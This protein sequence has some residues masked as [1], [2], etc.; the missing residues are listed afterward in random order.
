MTNYPFSI[1][2]AVLKT[3]DELKLSYEEVTS[4]PKEFDNGGIHT[5]LLKSDILGY[6]EGKEPK[7]VTKGIM[8]E[9]RNGKFRI[10]LIF[11]I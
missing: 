5:F 4:I 2:P 10:N 11:L 6:V 7:K 8:V 9:L 3:V 1:S